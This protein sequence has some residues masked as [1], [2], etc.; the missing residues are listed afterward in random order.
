MP[1]IAKKADSGHGNA[2]SWLMMPH[3][4]PATGVRLPWSAIPPRVVAALEG[5][6]GAPVTGAT[7]Q[8]GGFSPGVAARVIAANDRRVFVKAVGPEPNPDSPGIHRQEARMIA[9]LPDGL[10]VPRLLWTYDEGED[11]WVV[12]ALDDVAGHT[13]QVPWSRQEL[14]R[15]IET[16]VALSASLTPSPIAAVTASD[17]F[18]T[19]ICGWRQLQEESPNWLDAWSSR[20]LAALASI[21]AAASAAVQGDT[22]LHFDLRADNLLITPQRVFVVDWPHA[23]VGAA[24]VDLVAFAPSV[25]MQGG[26]DPEELLMRH[27]ATKHADREAITAAL[28]AI[29]GY[30]T[31]SAQAPPPPGIPTLRAFQAAQGVEARRWLARRTGW[32]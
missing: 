13:P 3:P 17:R 16:L 8:A 28:C 19:R 22:L 21:E 23:C 25:A 29:A 11:G 30:F 26:P 1:M 24:W 15:V 2:V 20:H 10:P 5:W 12:L 31:R 9:A 32:G 27:P 4:P 6:L 14:D 7:L 18:A